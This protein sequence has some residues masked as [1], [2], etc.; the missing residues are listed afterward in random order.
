[1]AVLTWNNSQVWNGPQTWDGFFD[2]GPPEPGVGST[3]ITSAPYVLAAITAAPLASSTT[4][5]AAPRSTGTTITG[6]PL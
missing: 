4:I 1:V 5:L 3:V 2:D 6:A